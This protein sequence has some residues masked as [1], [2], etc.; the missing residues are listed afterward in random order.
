[1]SRAQMRAEVK[2]KKGLNKGKLRSFGGFLIIAAVVQFVFFGL[3]T[4]AQGVPD[5]AI[6]TNLASAIKSGSY[7]PDGLTDRMGG[8]SDTFTECIVAATGLGQKQPE[9]LFVKAAYMPRLG[10]CSGGAKPILTLASG[11]ALPDG[12]V[13]SYSKYWAGY[14]VITRPV[15]AMFGL[16]GMRIVSGAML[17]FSAI[18][19]VVVLGRRTGMWTAAGLLLPLGLASNLMSTPSGSFS[20]AISIS[21]MF[22]GVAITAWSATKSTKWMIFGVGISAALFCYVDL[23][24]TPAI[25]WA[26]SIVVVA[27]L[28]YRRTRSVRSTFLSGIGAA[29]VWIIAFAGTWF[30]RWVFAALFLG[31][32]TTYKT[33]VSNIEFRTGG[34]HANVSH[35]LFAPTVANWSYWTSHISTATF[36]LVLT[37]IVVLLAL[38]MTWKRHGLATVAAWPVLVLSASVVIIWYEVLNNHSQIHAFFVY[39]GLPTILGVI[40]FAALLLWQMPKQED[41]DAVLTR[42]TPLSERTNGEV[43][44]HSLSFENENAAGMSG[45]REEET[46]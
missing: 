12:I 20:Q 10:S 14:T 34:D 18:L 3:L 41:G 17:L 40:L 2:A 46:V 29:A 37:C 28:S 19:A 42:S 27:G 7:G 32:R 43:V 33:I 39:R 6:Q 8:T 31:V 15:I 38:A 22:F 26:M 21:V 30:S 11:E 36:V 44:R 35:D 13:S 9:N 45:R 16:P 23:L 1:M 5:S 4:A 24:T 25:P